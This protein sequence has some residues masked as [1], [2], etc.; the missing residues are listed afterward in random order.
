MATTPIRIKVVD[1]CD[2]VIKNLSDRFTVK[3][4]RN[5]FSYILFVVE[6]NLQDRSQHRDGKT[7]ENR[8][9][10]IEDDTF[11]NPEFIRWNKTLEN[12]D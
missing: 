3:F 2:V 5:K 9:E 4:E 8:M 11:G 12:K 10:E 7:S 6:Y 1:R